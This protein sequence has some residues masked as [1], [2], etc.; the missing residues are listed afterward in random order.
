VFTGNKA[1][2]AGPNV[3]AAA[4]STG[5]PVDLPSRLLGLNGQGVAGPIVEV[6][7]EGEGLGDY[8]SSD[9]VYLDLKVHV[10]DAWKQPVTG[11]P[12]CSVCFGVMTRRVGS[13]VY[14]RAI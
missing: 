8:V 14:W 6:V 10:L 5:L 13:M 12:L 1:R 3:Y 9:D 11:K 4:P 2:W 7:V